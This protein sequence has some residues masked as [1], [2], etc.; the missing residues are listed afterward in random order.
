MSL[1]RSHIVNMQQ[2]QHTLQSTASAEELKV[3]SNQ[4]DKINSFHMQLLMQNE[5]RGYV[6]GARKLMKKALE[7]LHRGNFAR[8]KVCGSG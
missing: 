6:F 1:K 8:C 7:F 3:F 5:G 2:L 4:T